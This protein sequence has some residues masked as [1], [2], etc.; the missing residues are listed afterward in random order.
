MKKRNYQG[1]TLLEMMVVLFIISVLVLLFVP[2]LTKQ[3]DN[4]DKNGKEALQ[5]VVVSQSTLF[6]MN[7]SAE[8]TYENLV[9]SG[10]LTEDQAQKA[11]DWGIRLP[12]N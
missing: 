6:N 3:K 11:Q 7:E 4:V 10:Y 12:S 1:F 9:S 2:N 5:S 8:L